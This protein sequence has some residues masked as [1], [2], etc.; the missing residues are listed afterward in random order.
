MADFI[1]LTGCDGTGK[2]TQA[3]LLIEKFQN[4]GVN[5]Q[6]LWLRFPFFTCIP[7]LMFA[8]WRGYSWYENANGF[9]HGYWD[10]RESPLL[11]NYLP[12]CLLLDA[13]LA[14]IRKIYLPLKAGRLIICER[15]VIDMI[16]DLSI[17]CNDI[18]L[19]RRYPG[20]LFLYLLPPK[21]K[22]FVL[23]LN[24][25]SIR[26]RRPDLRTDKRLE[27]RSIAYKHLAR[28]LS[29]TTFSSNDEMIELHQQIL[30][31]IQTPFQE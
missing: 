22:I 31:R 23:D 25:P 18:N 21:S 26:D 20:K 24:V 27:D 29:L 10:F 17:A 3:R 13:A 28:E 1:Y 11:R 6:H 12:W 16:I 9:R 7:L 14:A 30:A 8:R 4:R 5:V 15:F 2:S 19:F